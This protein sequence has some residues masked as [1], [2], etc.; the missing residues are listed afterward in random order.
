MEHISTARA[1]S[2]PPL[3]TGGGTAR[4]LY[5][6]RHWLPRQPT[7]GG[8]MLAV[9]KMPLGK[10]LNAPSSPMPWEKVWECRV[11]E[12]LC[13]LADICSWTCWLPEYTGSLQPC[14]PSHAWLHPSLLTLHEGAKHSQILTDA[15]GNAGQWNGVIKPS[16]WVGSNAAQHISLCHLVQR[17]T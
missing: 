4:I 2:A 9:P 8:T 10:I 7:P 1:L 12:G 13:S 6:S 17:G 11:S 3:C 16:I 5:C 15:L 14:N